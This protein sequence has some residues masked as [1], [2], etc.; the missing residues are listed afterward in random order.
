MTHMGACQTYDM[1]HLLDMSFMRGTCLN[2][3][4]LD[5]HQLFA[6]LQHFRD[7]CRWLSYI[8]KIIFSG[9]PSEC[10]NMSRDM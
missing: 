10:H 9:I 4:R 1:L 5:R 7:I 3:F 2:V 8:F 6:C